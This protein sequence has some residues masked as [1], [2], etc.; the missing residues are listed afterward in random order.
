LEYRQPAA[1]KAV[2]GV[3]LPAAA[4]IGW[5][6]HPSAEH[7]AGLLQPIVHRLTLGM[8]HA[9]KILFL[10][11]LLI[12]A[13]C[14]QWWA[15]GSW[16]DHRVTRNKLAGLRRLAFTITVAGLLSMI[17]C[18]AGGWVEVLGNLAAL[19]AAIAWL[20]LLLG[21]AADLAISIRNLLSKAIGPQPGFGAK[22]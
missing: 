4:L 18:Y 16:L 10:D 9:P 1:A 22:S 11:C 2:Y 19:T 8:S 13:I 15:V 21:A 17:L 5:F 7:S 3:E 20:G 14:G 12:L 6:W